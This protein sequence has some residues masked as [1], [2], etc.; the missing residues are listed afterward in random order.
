[1]CGVRIDQC[2]PIGQNASRRQELGAN[3]DFVIIY[4]D[5]VSI[6]MRAE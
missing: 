4:D 6:G 5:L 1:M 3:D 2:S